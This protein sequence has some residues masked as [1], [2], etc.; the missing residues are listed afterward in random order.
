MITSA[1]LKQVLKGE[2]RLLKARDVHKCNPPR[3]D[4]VSVTALYEYCMKLPDMAQ[5]FPDAYP[6][7]RGC[8][9]EYFF[10]V[11]ATVQPDYTE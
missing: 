9:R 2:K 10:S 8:N 5:Y 1:W 7:G 6:K 11:L 3:Y 4:E